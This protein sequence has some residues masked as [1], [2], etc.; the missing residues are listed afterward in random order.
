MSEDRKLL[1]PTA[2]IVSIALRLLLALTAVGLVFRIVRGGWTD[3][4]VCITDNSTTGSTD[5]GA[6]FPEKGALVDAIP[7]YCAE[8][9]ST[10]LRLLDEL[11]A[12]PSTLLL[13]SGLFLLHRLLRDAAR[14]G[15]HTARTASRL[16]VLGWWLLAGSLVAE[17]VEANAGAALLAE[18]STTAD[19]TAGAWLTM[20]SAPYLA[21]LTGLGLLT[22]ARITR[23]GADMHEDLAGVV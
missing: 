7:R 23:A 4:I 17:F 16:R 11:S 14:E 15:V 5:A 9:P 18:L 10:Y 1:E 20:W 13:L 21:L 8:A 12:L 19:L 6:F 3:T 22:F 2:T